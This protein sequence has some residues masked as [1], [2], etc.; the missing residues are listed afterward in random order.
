MHYSYQRISQ[1]SL[2]NIFQSCNQAEDAKASLR[3]PL[4]ESVCISLAGSSLRSWRRAVGGCCRA[5][6]TGSHLS[7]GSERDTG[8]TAAKHSPGRAGRLEPTG[9]EG[10]GVRSV[11]LKLYFYSIFQKQ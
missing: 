8:T 6:P 2:L 10:R 11:G 7:A 4:P 5:K 1:E 9:T 3:R